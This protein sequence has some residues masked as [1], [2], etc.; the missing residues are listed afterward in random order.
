MTRHHEAVLVSARSTHPGIRY[1]EFEVGHKDPFEFLAGQHIYLHIHEQDRLQSRPFSIA[2]APRADHRFE[3]CL[4]LR[5]AGGVSSR[6]FALRPGDK[7]QFT[8]PHGTFTLHEPLPPV[9]VFI[10][11]GTG[12]APIRAMLQ[13]YFRQPDS[14]E[15]WLLFGARN[16]ADILYREEFESKSR[17]IRSF[18]FI[19]TLSRP[20]PGWAGARGYVQDHLESHLAGKKGLHAYI[21]GRREMVHEVHRRLAALGYGPDALTCEQL[22]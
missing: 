7:V 21:C 2:S 5:K 14:R 15:V 1:L 4:N 13:H 3:L 18:H 9:L 12:I 20:L 22:S 16:E 17:E 8:G 19:P 10:A 6:L 11:T